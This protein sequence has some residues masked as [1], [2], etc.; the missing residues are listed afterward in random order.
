MLNPVKSF[1]GMS[2]K[3]V[4]VRTA[5]NSDFGFEFPASRPLTTAAVVNASK[6]RSSR[7]G[8][9]P[10]AEEGAWHHGGLNE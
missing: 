1:A 6:V 9:G 8:R 10:L 5:N 4:A 3:V 7:T 2:L